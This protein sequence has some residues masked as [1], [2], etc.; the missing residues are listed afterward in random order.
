M[1]LVKK[2]RKKIKKGRKKQEVQNVPAKPPAIAITGSNCSTGGGDNRERE[3]KECKR[4]DMQVGGCPLQ[5]VKSDAMLQEVEK[6]DFTDE[7]LQADYD[8]I[9]VQF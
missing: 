2:A 3:G 1:F 5:K 4:P 7:G 9:G 8:Y 6:I